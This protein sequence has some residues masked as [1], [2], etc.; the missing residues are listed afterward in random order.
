VQELVRIDFFAVLPR[1]LSCK[2]LEYLDAESLCKVAQVSRLWQ[3]LADNDTVWQKM[4]EQHI[5]KKCS[6]CGWGLP[7]L[8]PDPTKGKKRQKHLQS[9]VAGITG[10]V[11]PQVSL[12][13]SCETAPFQSNLCDDPLTPSSTKRRRN[14]DSEES[15]NTISHLVRPWKAAYKK[16]FKIG[17]G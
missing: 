11:R 9:M 3:S 4:C 14:S 16:S 15:S 12:D 13:T 17:L 7:G 5:D 1:E 2:V 6:K 10:I 8:L